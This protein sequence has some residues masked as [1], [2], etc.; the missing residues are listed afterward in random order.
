VAAGSKKFCSP[1]RER[2]PVG[3]LALGVGLALS[4]TA[5]G[6]LLATAGSSFGLDPDTFRMVGAVVLAIFR[7]RS[8]SH[9]YKAV[10]TPDQRHGSSSRPIAVEHDLDSLAGQFCL[11]ALLG[12]V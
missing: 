2:T 6:I 4:F 12:V 10:R 9:S 3:A 11:G 1:P 5:V 8:S 7:P